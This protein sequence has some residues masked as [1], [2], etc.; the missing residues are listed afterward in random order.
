VRWLLVA[1]VLVSCTRN[2]RTRC[3]STCVREAQCADKLGPEGLEMDLASCIDTC[4]ALERDGTGR[5]LVEAHVKCVDE[6]TTCELLA[7]CP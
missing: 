4:H 3:Q 2:P 6:A 1:A 5:K 7:A